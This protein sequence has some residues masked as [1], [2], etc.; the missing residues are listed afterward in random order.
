[1]ASFS[2]I[3]KSLFSGLKYFSLL[4]QKMLSRGHFSRCF[5]SIGLL[6]KIFKLSFSEKK[7]FV[8]ESSNS[9]RIKTYFQ[10]RNIVLPIEI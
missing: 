6:W 1:M 8:S 10:P 3:C 9:F 2:V 5:I 7:V 4:P